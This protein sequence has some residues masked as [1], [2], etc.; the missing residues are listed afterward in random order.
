MTS[1]KPIPEGY[2]PISIYI[3]VRDG[4]AALAFYKQ[5]L[6]AVEVRLDHNAAGK[7]NNIELKVGT[8]MIMIGMTPNAKVPAPR[9]D[10]LPTVSA[11]LYVEDVDAVFERML[12]AGATAL[13]PP[14][15]QIYGDRRADVV[16]PFGVLW[17]V[18]SRVEN[19]SPEEVTRRAQQMQA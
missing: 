1:V 7:L 14:T 13:N 12:A 18:A 16:D 19:V 4:E 10:D 3:L 11:Y 9:M 17:W 5:A 8:S 2:P 6:G 15:D